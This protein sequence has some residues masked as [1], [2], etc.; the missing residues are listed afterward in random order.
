MIVIEVLL[1]ELVNQRFLVEYTLLQSRCQI[2]SYLWILKNLFP[3]N[4]V[5]EFSLKFERRVFFEV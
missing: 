2:Y 3:C 5:T 4:V 1:M